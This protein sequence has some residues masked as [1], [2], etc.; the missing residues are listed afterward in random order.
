MTNKVRV[1]VRAALQVSALATLLVAGA[2]RPAASALAQPSSVPE[3]QGT[4]RVFPETSFGVDDAAVWEYFSGRGGVDSFGYPA[5]RTFRL[6]GFPVQVFQRHVL[7]VWPDGSVHP[8]NL[9]DPDVMPVTSVNFSR[10]PAHDP[11]VAGAAPPPDTPAY[12]AAV[13]AHL[14]ATVPDTFQ[15]QPV[16]FLQTYLAAAPGAQGGQA[17]L[18]ALELWGF[19]TSLPAADP[20]NAGFVYQRFQR[21]ILHYDAT[22]GATRGML[23]ADTLKAVLTGRNVPRDVELELQSTRFRRQYCPSFAGWLCRPADLPATDLRL[24]FEPPPVVPA[25][26]PGGWTPVWNDLPVDG[27]LLGGNATFAV[28]PVAESGGRTRTLWRTESMGTAA[29][30]AQQVFTPVEGVNDVAVHPTDSRT[31]YVAGQGGVYRSTNGGATWANVLAPPPI[32]GFPQVG[33]R[34]VVSPANP[35]LLYAAASATPAPEA[36]VWRSL[37]GGT[38]WQQIQPLRA[39]LCGW[40]FPIIAPDPAVSTRVYLSYYCAAG[41]NTSANVSVS[42]DQWTTPGRVILSPSLQAQDPLR[43]LFPLDVAFDPSGAHGVVLGVRDIR[44]GGSALVR[45]DDGGATWQSLL[46]QLDVP[47]GFP[48][49]RQVALAALAAEVPALNRLFAGVGGATGRGVLGSED[50]GATWGPV[51]S[52]DM[53]PV[54]ALALDSARNLL[55]AGASTGLWQLADPRPSTR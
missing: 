52:P 13:L 6:L 55:F 33:L 2:L 9:L 28:A 46:D 47:S 7:Q 5:S 32:E 49:Q 23:L 40:T 21:G 22:T 17:A 29:T 37:D 31:I 51:G 30:A 24:A 53:G 41:R 50:G 27:V 1:R 39:T 10:F 38:T 25:A 42:D 45:T 19:P 43:A 36:S 3:Q 14:R 26:T 15:G 18:V 35:S 4:I 8:L 20:T 12:G 44:L 11:A 16:N 34:V 48:L 54:A